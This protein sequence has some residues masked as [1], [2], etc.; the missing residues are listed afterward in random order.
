[1]ID[2][3]VGVAIPVYNGERFLEAALRSVLAQ[4]HQVADVLV[5]DD[6]SADASGE[7]ARAVGPPVRVLRRPHSGPGATRSLA[8]SLVRGEYIVPFD[9]DDLLTAT[10]IEARVRVLL[11]RPDV[12][13]VYGHVRSFRELSE[14]RP[15]PLDRPRPAHVTDAMLIRRTAYERVGPFAPG[16]RVA[17]CLDWLLRA[18]EI[19]LGEVTVRD[20]VLWRRVHGANNSLTGRSAMDEFPRALKASLDRRRAGGR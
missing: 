15:V 9:A 6:G 3:S 10:S 8:M 5:V 19:G 4:S 2:R 14:G 1:V 7:V 20:H 13:I 18:R 16:L 11:E 17:E 12:D